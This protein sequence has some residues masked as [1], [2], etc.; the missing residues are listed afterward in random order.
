VHSIR[1]NGCMTSPPEHAYHDRVSR[2]AIEALLPTKGEGDTWDFKETLGDTS[3]TGVRVNLAKDALAFC[4]LPRGG[5]LVIGVTK[6]YQLVGL[7]SSET[8]DTSTLRKAVEKYVDG[9]F[10]V[11]AAEHELTLPGET[12]PKRFGIVYFGRRTAQPV[13]AAIDGNLPSGC[14]FRQGD[15]L[16]RRGAQSIRA[17]S[18]E[19]RQL[20]TSTVVSGER[21]KAV[22]ELWR[23]IVEQRRLV[24]GLEVLYDILM[25]AEYGDV[26]TNSK[27]REFLG[28]LSRAEHAH[29]F[30]EL[31]LKVR[32]ARPHLDDDVYFQYRRCAAFVGRVQMKAIENRENGV[33]V[34][35][36]VLKDGSPDDALRTIATELVPTQELDQIW[37][38][39]TT[40]NGTWRPLSP[41]IDASE[42]VLLASIRAVLNGLS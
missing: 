3:S 13:L 42:G 16:V 29:R 4:N 23:A 14:L 11:V 19:V 36:N 35:W 28:D 20:L 7:R 26:M 9:D 5:S 21:V 34:A 38:G 24:T 18:G 8:I 27:V 6:D 39:S 1:D 31:Q 12:V 17:N 30:D 10:V 40:K 37:Q 22:N 25:E 32:L 15:I 41:L 33:F 2:S